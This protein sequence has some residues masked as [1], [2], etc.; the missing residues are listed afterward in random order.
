MIRWPILAIF[1]KGYP[2][3]Q[4]TGSTNCCR[5]TGSPQNNN[6]PQKEQG[7]QGGPGQGVFTGW[8]LIA[9]RKISF[10]CGFERLCQIKGGWWIAIQLIAYKPRKSLCS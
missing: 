3:S 7:P 8:I 6:T 2:P 4:T 9:Q 1:C 10:Y 5:T